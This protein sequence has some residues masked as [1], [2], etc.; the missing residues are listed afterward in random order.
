MIADYY[1]TLVKRTVTKV[2]DGAG[3]FTE[4]TADTQFQGAILELTGQ[5]LLR[6]Q[7]LQND[8]TA[9]LL[10]EEVIGQKNR[11]VDGSVEYEIVYHFSDF[12]HRYPLKRRQ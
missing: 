2:S 6:N 8:A 10:T 12:H 4:T 3:N 1:K 9:V 11:I 7:M 5:E